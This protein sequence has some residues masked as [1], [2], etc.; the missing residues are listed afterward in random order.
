MAIKAMGS[1]RIFTFLACHAFIRVA[2]HF[3]RFLPSRKGALSLLLRP[4]FAVEYPVTGVRHLQ[5]RRTCTSALRICRTALMACTGK[6]WAR[7][8][9]PWGLL[10]RQAMAIDNLCPA[11][12]RRKLPGLLDRPLRLRLRRGTGQYLLTGC[13]VGRFGAT[14]MRVRQSH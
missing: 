11:S 12:V 4:L 6:P 13:R 9:Q 1:A 5:R 3:S 8:Q 2:R 10:Y 7:V 14:E